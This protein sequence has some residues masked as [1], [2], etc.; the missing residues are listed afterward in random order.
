M[1]KLTA[2]VPLAHSKEGVNQEEWQTL[3]DHLVSVSEGAGEFASS[4]GYE[5]WGRALGLLH[6]AGKISDA[7][8]ARLRGAQIKVDHSTLGAQI[9]SDTYAKDAL[10]GATGRLMAF[11]IVGHHGGIPNGIVGGE[12]TPLR[13]R[14]AKEDPAD[15]RTAF[16]AFLKREC[17]ALPSIDELEKLPLECMA[18]QN[19]EIGVERGVFSTSVVDRMLFSCLV[20]AD[21]LDTEAFIT[22]DIAQARV[23]RSSLPIAELAS[24]LDTYLGELEESATASPVND[25]RARVLDECQAA[26]RDAPG[27]YSLTV[28]TGGGKTLSS[29]SFALHHAVEHGMDRVIYAIP[30]TSI[31]EQTASEFR[32]ALHDN[33]SILEHHSNYNFDVVEDDEGRISERLAIQNW[34]VPLVVT[35]N[36]QLLE[37]LFSNKPAKCRKLHNIANSVIVLDEAQ[38]LPDELM[39]VTLAMLEE[40]VADFNVSVVLCTATQP[41][42]EGL[43]PFHSQVH[44]IVSHQAE[45]TRVLGGRTRFEVEGPLEE[46]TLVK[47]LSSYEQVLCIVGTKKKARMVYQ[48]LVDSCL[49]NSERSSGKSFE[50]GVFHLSASMVPAHR[51]LVLAEIRR[52]LIEG[53]RCVV[54]STQLVEAG[55]DVDF[56]VVYREMAGIDSLVQA[57]GRCNREGRHSEGVVHIFEISDEVELGLASKNRA[58]GWLEK[59]KVLARAVI[60][61]HHGALDSTMVEEFFI[62]R[63]DASGGKRGLDSDGLYKRISSANLITGCGG[64]FAS[65]DFDDYAKAYKLIDDDNSVPVFVPWQDRGRQLMRELHDA[66]SRGVPPATF[67]SKLQSFSVSVPRWRF[68]RLR[69]E[70]AID[71][72]TYAPICVLDVVHDCNVLYSNE[73]GLMDLGEGENVD[74]I[75]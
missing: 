15:S 28:P 35:T 1:E 17:L 55:V 9:A 69:V 30:F 7:F 34:D 25:A 61:E 36:V 67:A 41:A 12:K 31:V 49:P 2:A 14:L 72:K 54:V 21:Y 44:E 3:H 32:K 4:F 27:I 20:D 53:R 10:S 24:R 37:S 59:M 70:G 65:L 51:S 48:D 22:P 39:T 42:L 56:P 46:S 6:D 8:Q 57:A 73:L 5:N 26:A 18:V 74:L 47:S 13:G 19:D 43:W 29:L 64:T 33:D 63:H 11:D 58:P 45:L 60:H 71:D 40:L 52:R 23:Q 62:A 66:C 75:F 16:E 50:E 38:T 68:D